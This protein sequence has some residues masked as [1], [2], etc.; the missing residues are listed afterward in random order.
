MHSVHI[1]YED[2]SVVVVDKPPGLSVHAD[3]KREEYTLVDW[4]LERYPDMR[5]VG[6]ALVLSSGEKILRPGIVHRL[7]RETSGILIVAKTQDAYLYIKEQFKN[8]QVKKIY[9]AFVYG[10]I[11][12]EKGIINFPIG[13]SRKDFRLRSAQPKAKGDLREAITHYKVLARGRAHTFLE[14]EAKTGRT[15]QIRVH[16]KA[17]HH[18]VIC[19]RLYAP[20]HPCAL[21]F[22]RLALHASVLEVQLPEGE[23]K[24]FEAPLPKEFETALELLKIEKR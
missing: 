6:E 14:L 2:T 12:N 5:D 21:G 15:H 16:L 7:D 24:K 17:I 9:S 23:I 10:V 20:N 13:R 8:R 4:L 22:S 18:P 3:G 1:V 19:D 11:K